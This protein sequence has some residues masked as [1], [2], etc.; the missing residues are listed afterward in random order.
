[1]NSKITLEFSSLQDLV[2]LDTLNITINVGTK[3]ITLNE[4]FVSVRTKIG[5]TNLETL[6]VPPNIQ[7]ASN[8]TD[9][10]NLDYFPFISA[11]AVNTGSTVVIEIP[12]KSWQ[13]ISASGTAI[14]SGKVSFTI[15]NQP[16]Q[17]E[18]L[19]V[20]NSYSSSVG[21][22]CTQAIANLDVTGGNN[23]YNVYVDNNL[24]LSNQT[25]P[26]TVNI[27]RGD[28]REIRVVDTD[29]VLIKT[30]FTSNTRKLI[31]SDISVN[32]SNLTSGATLNIS[33]SY[34]N[35]NISIYQYSLNGVDYQSSNIFTGIINGTYT[36]YV[37]DAFGCIISKEIIVNGETKVTDTVFY[38]SEINPIRFFSVNEEKKNY[39]NTISCNEL[40][41]NSYG[42]NQK[43]ISTDKQKI[44]FKTNANYINC[45]TLDKSQNTQQLTPIKKTENIGLQAKS[46]CIYFNIGD[47]KS[48]IY[49]G[50]V[51]LLDPITDDVIGNTDF[52]FSLPE[53]A[54]KEG[55]LVT[56]S[57]IGEVEIYKIGYS[58]FYESFILEFNISYDGNP[59]QKTLY[60]KYNLQPY[61]LYEFE[62]DM[63]IVP[64]LFN[65]VIECGV[66]EN[67]IDFT[68]I[69][70]TIEITE[71]S[72]F[73]FKI[74][75]YDD[76]NKGGFVYQTGIINLIRLN[77]YV[78]YLGE[79][80]TEGYDGDKEFYV[81]DNVVYNS[82]RFKF[83]RIPS[84][85]AHKLRMIVSHKYLLING[86][87][88]KLAETPEVN[89]DD[90]SNFKNF[91]VTLKNGGNQFL[92]D[93]QE[94]IVNSSEN[95]SI[96]AGIEASQGKGLIL[97]TKDNG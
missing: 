70:E 47:G 66:D 35:P 73:L 26:I 64:S 90:N 87:F 9:S 30:V 62:V 69:S 76:E 75:Y 36:L 7:N 25:T 41:L 67:T 82:E 77:G 94:I 80:S 78:D 86:V 15:E 31:T 93:E 53:W 89:G 83:L 79:Q 40:R 55:D 48:G 18:K 19:V 84:A 34:I 49:F 38:L 56:I 92:T 10:W 42:F 23:L 95:D 39:Y 54:N 2:L 13:F 28:S 8:Y 61:E 51:D 63:N 16:V 59:V 32:I 45:F 33:V 50:A 46:T 85:M 21:N 97:W 60:S 81:T 65:L 43:Y 24:S 96:F 72:P 5:E 11:I 22:E 20:I 27:T 4:T 6:E 91:F 52:G 57:G 14:T 12:E 74:Q 44:Q 3:N 17:T 88:Y 29:G 1:M 37:K 71:D 68:R 58:D